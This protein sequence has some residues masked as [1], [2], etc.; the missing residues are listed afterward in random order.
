MGSIFCIVRWII[1]RD[2][3]QQLQALPQLVPCQADFGPDPGHFLREGFVWMLFDKI[4]GNLERPVEVT[5]ILEHKAKYSQKF[6]RSFWPQH[7]FVFLDGGEG[8]EAVL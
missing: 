5:V 7:R 3:V 8:C 1:G 6:E 2:H 4:V